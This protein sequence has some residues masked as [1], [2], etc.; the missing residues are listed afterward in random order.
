MN[1][2]PALFGLNDITEV[3][4]ELSRDNSRE[5]T[6]SLVSRGFDQRLIDRVSEALGV[7]AHV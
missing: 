2:R 4:R 7:H 3:V 6:V 5:R 1:Y